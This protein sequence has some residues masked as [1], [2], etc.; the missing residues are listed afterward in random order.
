MLQSL[1]FRLL[2]ASILL[3]KSASNRT[4]QHLCVSRTG[5]LRKASRLSKS[6]PKQ[7]MDRSFVYILT[8][9]TTK[10][11]QKIA[12]NSKKKNGSRSKLEHKQMTA[13]FLLSSALKS[14]LD[15]ERS[16]ARTLST[17]MP[18]ILI[19]SNTINTETKSLA[20]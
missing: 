19:P 18:Q 6:Q 2:T 8:V 15:A 13:S 17:T 9:S 3:N 11:S 7:R 20:G 4:M 14:S 5:L 12:A 1:P 16:G 10:K